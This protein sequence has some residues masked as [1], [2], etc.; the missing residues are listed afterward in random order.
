GESRMLRN[1]LAGAGHEV[2]AVEMEGAAVAQVCLDY[3]VPFAAVRTIS[4]RADD[5][6]HVDFPSFVEQVASRYAQVIIKNFLKLL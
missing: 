5:S 4:D 3:G 1:S 2:L 6:A